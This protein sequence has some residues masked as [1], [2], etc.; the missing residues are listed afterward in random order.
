MQETYVL[1]PIDE[2]KGII[3]GVYE[4]GPKREIITI[5][6]KPGNLKNPL[7]SRNM[8]VFGSIGSRK[9]KGILLP[10]VYDLIVGKNS[11]VTTDPKGEIYRETYAQAKHFGYNILV[12]NTLNFLASDGW[13]CLKM[14]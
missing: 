14:V 6:F 7:P 10:N 4:E 1:R 13:D 5:P 2:P 9:T 8:A 3:V 11:I 12:F